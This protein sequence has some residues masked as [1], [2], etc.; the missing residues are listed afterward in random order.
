[1]KPVLH[2]LVV[3]CV[4]ALPAPALAGFTDGFVEGDPGIASISRLEFGPEGVL[5]IG[6]SKGGAVI[7]VAT[8]DVTPAD[9]TERFSVPDL[10]GKVAALLG[11]APDDVLIH[12]MAV[13][14]ISHAVYLSVS[15][16]RT[17]WESRWDLPNELADADIVLR[18]DTED[19]ITEVPLANVPHAR[20]ELPNAVDPE[21]THRWK[22][23][24]SLRVDA[25]TALVYEEG[26]LYVTG[27]SNEEFSAALWYVDFPFADA[28]EW[29]TL[30]IYHGAHGQWETFAPIR[31]FLPYEFGGKEHILASYLCTPLVTFPM[32]AIRGGEH[33]KGHTIAELGA[34]NFPLDMVKATHGETT[35]FVLANSQ[36]PLM[37]FTPEAVQEYMGKPGITRESPTYTEG[38]AGTYRAGSGVQQLDNFNA[39]FIIALQRMASG[40]LDLVALSV[41]RLAQS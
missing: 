29:G 10:E 32:E 7:A 14:P 25:I 31:A 38:L 3:L 1:M 12:D 20:F 41:E 16:G 4:F 30:E 33:V 22:E 11:T 19:T 36:L 9:R 21:K 2:S 23:G 40:K 18:I 13:N 24:L 39:D 26:T 8:G 28:A 27:L 17:E 15:R 37:T 34:G 5:F 6:D 35:V